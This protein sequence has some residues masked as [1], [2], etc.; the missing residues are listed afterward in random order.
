MILYL[1]GVEIQLVLILLD[2]NQR[3]KTFRPKI[4]PILKKRNNL[5]MNKIRRL[6]KIKYT[7][8]TNFLIAESKEKRKSKNRRRYSPKR[9]DSIKNHL[10]NKRFNKRRFRKRSGQQVQLIVQ[11]NKRI[12]RFGTIFNFLKIPILRRALES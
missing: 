2:Q 1:I 4:H 8:F 12:K 11:K 5:W 10:K 6:F 3:K 7:R 9:L